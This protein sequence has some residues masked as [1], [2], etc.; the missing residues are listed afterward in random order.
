MIE[1]QPVAV[2]SRKTSASV[3]VAIERAFAVRR[4]AAGL[5]VH[6]RSA[7]LREIAAGVRQRREEFARIIASEGIKTIR[8]ARLEAD[9]CANTFELSAEECSRLG[10]ETVA[11]DQVPKGDGRIGWWSRRPLGVVAGL[12]PY[13]DPLNLVAHKL[14]PAIAAGAPIIAKP[15]PRT[16]SVALELS[17]LAAA[18][19]LP[20]GMV[21]VITGGADVALALAKDPRIA[22][23]SFTGG[24]RA[25]AAIAQVAAGKRLVMEMGG[26]CASVVAKDADLVHATEALASGIVSAAGQN[27]V[28][29]QRIDVEAEIFDE[30]SQRLVAK[31]GSLRVGEQL[32]EATDVGPLLDEKHA[33]N[34][35]DIIR[36]AVSLGAR[37]LCGATRDGRFLSPTLVTDVPENHPLLTEEMFAPV[38]AIRSGKSMSG[39]IEAVASSGHM[40]N[41]SIFTQRLDLILAFRNVV[42]AGAIIVNDSTDFRIDAMPFGGNGEAG[43]GREGV[44]FAIESLTERQLI[45][46]RA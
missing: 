31:L 42:E 39:I 28:H 26:V 38:A 13:N 45:C 33:K 44:R 7:S 9:R 40:I 25:G 41:A 35:E 17:R 29:T 27:C 24:R 23:V 2:L 3:A 1:T 18:T 34:V 30:L 5:S 46:L 15:H 20:A 22:V 10:G 32:A 6:R 14:G 11:F 43:L 37:V 12:T 8:E 4:Q 16:P 36:D 19:D 21:Q